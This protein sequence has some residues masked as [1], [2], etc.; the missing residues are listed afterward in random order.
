[1]ATLRD[2][3]VEKVIQGISAPEEIKRVIFTSES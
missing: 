3:A 1:M 2:A